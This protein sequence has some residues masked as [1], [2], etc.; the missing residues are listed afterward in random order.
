MA[1]HRR[2]VQL[3]PLSRFAVRSRN[4]PLPHRHPTLH[5]PG[6]HP[7]DPNPRRASQ[8]P[9]ER[10]HNT[11]DRALG[12]RI[13]ELAN[14]S[15]I[16]GHGADDD[17]DAALA[18]GWSGVDGSQIGEGLG[19]EVDGAAQVDGEGA[20]EGGH[21]H[22]LNLSLLSIGVLSREGA[23]RVRDARTGDDAAEGVADALGESDSGADGGDD[24]GSGGDVG[25]GVE[26]VWGGG[27]WGGGRG[28][29]E[30]EDGDGGVVGEEVG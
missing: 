28:W 20:V 8:L 16:G 29:G 1:R 26:D 5:H 18:V 27:E 25:A 19:D 22:G 23:L 6:R 21:G 7:T 30:V 3:L 11:R 15:F 13:R 10:K 2:G 4:P 24:G 12:G 9:R 17:H 14:L